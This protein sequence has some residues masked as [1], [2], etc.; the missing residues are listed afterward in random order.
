M[1]GKMQNFGD[2]ELSEFTASLGVELGALVP[3]TDGSIT[4]K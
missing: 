2:Y 1:L 3:K 4:I